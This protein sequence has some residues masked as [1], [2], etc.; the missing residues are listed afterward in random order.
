MHFIISIKAELQI[1]V[2]ERLPKCSFK[3]VD[4]LAVQSGI[5]KRTLE[6]LV[7]FKDS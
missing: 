5:R 6:S 1:T 2:Q 3:R 4:S 7:L